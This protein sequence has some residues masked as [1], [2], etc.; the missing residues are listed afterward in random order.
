[1]SLAWFP[2]SVHTRWTNLQRADPRVGAGRAQS[3]SK[4]LAYRG[5]A[6]MLHGGPA[7]VIFLDRRSY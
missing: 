5:Q 1:M 4:D 3:M 2:G 7:F 6:L